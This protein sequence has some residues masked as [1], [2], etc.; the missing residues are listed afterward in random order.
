MKQQLKLLFLLFLTTPVF[1]Q[2]GWV[3]IFN[4]QDLT[5]WKVGANASSFSVVD[6]AIQIA[7]PRAHLFYEGA[8]KNHMFKNFEFQAQVMTKPGANSGIY[9]HTAYQEDGWPSQGYEIQVNNS[10]TDWKRTGSLYDIMDVK[11][12]YAKDNEWYTEYIKVEG[13]HITIKINDKVVVDF[14]ESDPDKRAVNGKGRILSSGTFALQAHD[15]KSV[16]LY[17]DIKVK[18]L[19]E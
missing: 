16:V 8:V 19:T 10:H 7:G 1:A 12:T 11:E 5:G 14:E 3:S 18:P 17:K 2:D 13:K 9:I 15:P 6:G 4:G